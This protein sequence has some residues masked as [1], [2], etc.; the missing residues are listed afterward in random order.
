MSR[1][2]LELLEKIRQTAKRL[3]TSNPDF[4]QG[5]VATSTVPVEFFSAIYLT[6]IAI[7]RIQY[8]EQLTT[9][10]DGELKR[11]IENAR[12]YKWLDQRTVELFEDLLAIL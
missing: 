11:R 8:G 2:D 5:T 7:A 1:P 3:G 9:S 10:G 12:N 4:A 6:A